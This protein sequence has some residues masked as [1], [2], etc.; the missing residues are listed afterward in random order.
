ME[1]FEI[2]R[3][4]GTCKMFISIF[5]QANRVKDVFEMA[6]AGHS[7]SNVSSRGDNELLSASADRLLG[8]G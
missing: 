4:T 2:E 6:N 8:L 5:I 3:E 1:W 7:F